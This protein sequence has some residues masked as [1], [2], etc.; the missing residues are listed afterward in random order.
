MALHRVRLSDR[1]ESIIEQVRAIGP[2]LRERAVV[3]DS[4]SVSLKRQ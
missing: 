3:A 4:Q 2:A 1:T